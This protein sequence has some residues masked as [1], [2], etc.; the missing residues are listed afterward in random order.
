MRRS[1]RGASVEKGSVRGSGRK[2]SPPGGGRKASPPVKAAPPGSSRKAGSPVKSAPSSGRK[3]SPPVKASPSSGRKA[4]P[5]VKASPSSGRKAS[6]PVKA[7]PSSGRKAAPPAGKKARSGDLQALRTYQA[8]RRFDQTPEPRGDS[9]RPR[10][11]QGLEFVVQKHD[12]SHLHYDFRL[13]LDGVLLSWAVPKGPSL[14]PGERRLAMRTEDHPLDYASFEGVIPAGEYGGGSVLVWDRGVW[15]PDGDP[16]TSLKKGRLTFALQG[17]KLSGRFHLVRTGSTKDR[18][19][20]WLLFKSKDAAARAT[21]IVE[22]RPESVLSGKTIDEIDPAAAHATGP[23]RAEPV[24]DMVEMVKRLAPGFALTN[25]DK[26]LYPEQGL[27]K[28]EIIAYYVSVASVM[29]PQVQQRPLVLVRCPEGRRQ[30]CFYQKHVGKGIPNAVGRVSVR[31]SAKT[32]DYATLHDLNGLIALA[33]LGVLEIHTWQ[34]HADK[35]E[36]PDQFVFDIDPDVGLAWERVVDAALELKL[37]LSELGLTSFVKTTGGK[38]LHVVVPVARRLDWEQHK[39]VSRAV[40]QA[41]V[42]KQPQRYVINMRKDLR[43]GK[44]F[45]DYLRNGRGASAIAPYSTRAREN[46]PVATPL[47]WDELEQGAK[48]SDF[49]VRSVLRRLE[50]QKVDPWQGFFELNQSIPA[51]K[52]RQLLR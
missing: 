43:K 27:R 45:L 22:E 51:A 25:L 16:Q 38:G 8:K 26:V 15:L 31:E 2:A 42:Q 39:A 30:Q 18:R 29:L 21:D 23:S 6:P 3:A 14:R 4:S 33:Q 7:S 44:I 10:A 36:K 20:R 47:R 17:E 12:A 28:A 24:P 13:E 34:C 11:H 49:D 35:L 52:L 37:A 41:L 19:E 48:P 1:A 40:V 5:P 46:A 32:V 50:D 9:A